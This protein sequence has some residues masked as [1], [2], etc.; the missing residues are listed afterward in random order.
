MPINPYMEIKGSLYVS[1]EKTCKTGWRLMREFWEDGKR[2]Q[3]S[4]P[5]SAWHALGFLPTMS[6]EEARLRAKTI[7]AQN[8]ILRREAMAKARIA[9]R[10]ERDALAHT[11]FIPKNLNEQFKNWL[12]ENVTGSEKHLE[13]ILIQWNRV[14]KIIITL[15]LIPSDYAHN[16]KK[17]YRYFISQEYSLDYT[18][19]LL[20]LLNLYGR[21][22][23]RLT[24]QYFEPIEAPK[25]HDREMINDAYTESSSY[26]GPSD[27]ITPEILKSVKDKIPE[28]SWNWLFISLWFGLRPSELEMCLSDPRRWRVEK[29]EKDILWVYQNKLTSKPKHLRWKPIPILFPE[30]TQALKILREGDAAKPLAKTMRKYLS[31]YGH[32]TTYCGRKGFTDLMLARK[33]KLEDIAHWLGHSSIE[34][35]WTVYKD[36]RKVSYTA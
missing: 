19:K 26:Y 24:G 13:K 10:I 22:V 18:K 11:A 23:A 5:K 29:G 8:S 16:K 25:G 20:R 1:K 4:I 2:R 32:L 35:T 36:K 28:K 9:E 30:Q 34:M 31:D 17:I 27:P 12:Q 33:Q 7:N 14:K 15:E 21:F 6:L 3:R